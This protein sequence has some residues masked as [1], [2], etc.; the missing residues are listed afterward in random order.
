[1][2]QFFRTFSLRSHKTAYQLNDAENDVTAS[3]VRTPIRTLSIRRKFPLKQHSMV[4]VKR[5]LDMKSAT[6]SKH[7]SPRKR[8]HIDLPPTS[9]TPRTQTDLDSTN[10]SIDV[11]EAVKSCG[12]IAEFRREHIRVQ[13]HVDAVRRPTGDNGNAK[14]GVSHFYVF[15]SLLRVVL[16]RRHMRV[17]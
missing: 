10:S 8:L 14:G 16:V 2:S 13:L 5:A 3:V 11:C 4:N 6:I 12:P 17:H 9:W 15:C 1:M 7:P